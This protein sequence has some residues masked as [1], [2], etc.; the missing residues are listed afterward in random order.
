MGL[1]QHIA[2]GAKLERTTQT[3]VTNVSGS[4]SVVFPPA[5]ALL[6]I[7]ASAPCR[8]R[9][10]DTEDAWLDAG[11]IARPYGNLNI[12]SSIA[13]IGDFTMSA[14]VQNFIDPV[15]YSVPE[16]RDGT[17]YYRMDPSGSA[18]ITVTQYQ[19]DDPTVVPTPNTAYTIDNRRTVTIEELGVASASF[20][21]GTLGT[22]PKTYLLVSASLADADNFARLRLYRISDSLNEVTE[23]LRPFSV[24][25]SASVQLIVDMILTGSSPVYFVP[26]LIGANLDNMGTDLN[27]IKGTRA[28]FAG[29]PELYYILNNLSGSLADIEVSLHLFA[30]ED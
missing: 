14:N 3:F 19:L 20:A 5:S 30:L 27:V 2:A 9:L 18:T 21:S 10:Y 28:S 7:Q 23:Q 6:R 22:S 25:P 15:L 24:E 17:I 4:G 11:E 16:N 26:K 29:K 12:S 8:L 1:R 13:L